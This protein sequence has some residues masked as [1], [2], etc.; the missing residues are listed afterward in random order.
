MGSRFYTRFDT[1]NNTEA[2]ASTTQYTQTAP[3]AIT[4][5]TNGTVII[6]NQ[7]CSAS[8][9]TVGLLLRDGDNWWKSNPLSIQNGPAVNEFALNTMTWVQVDKSAGTP[10][11]DMDQV[12]NK[13]EMGPLTYGAAGTPV[14]TAI[15]G[16]GFVFE[17]PTV[18]TSDQMQI[19]NILLGQIPQATGLTA[20][21][22]DSKIALSWTACADA[23]AYNVYRSTTASG[24][25]TKLG[26]STTTTYDDTT[27]AK[28]TTYFYVV[29][30]TIAPALTPAK[31]A[32]FRASNEASATIPK[33]LSGAKNWSIFK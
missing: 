8:D 26:S 12:D 1:S 3:S 25:Y 21:A 18:N 24:P 9:I 11:E 15:Q 6:D 31:T 13:G 10:G 32:P 4:D 27:A 22:S 16:M 30:G 28:G 17:T 19:D 20:T 5:C 23:T 33:P 2:A 7:A 14:F 29:R